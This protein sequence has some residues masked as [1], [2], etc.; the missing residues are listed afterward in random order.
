MSKSKTKKIRVASGRTYPKARFTRYVYMP[1]Q[2]LGKWVA[3]NS[4]HFTVELGSPPVIIP[5][6]YV[7]THRKTGF[8]ISIFDEDATLSLVQV[9]AKNLDELGKACWDFTDNRTTATQRWRK[10]YLSTVRLI[11]GKEV[12]DESKGKEDAQ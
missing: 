6:E 5:D 9:M 2:W 3:V 11:L 4:N 12:R 1:C 10:K 7:I 8:A